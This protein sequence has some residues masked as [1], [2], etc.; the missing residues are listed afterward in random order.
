MKST[1]TLR[2]IIA[3]IEPVAG[4]CA[5]FEAELML[6]KLCGV[7]RHDLYT[8]ADITVDK[9]Q[10]AVLRSWIENRRSHVP[11]AHI[12]HQWHFYSCILT[13]TPHVLIPRSET[14]C[15]I[16][17]IL[18]CYSRSTHLYFCDIGTGSGNITAA[19]LHER[20]GWRAVSTDI[21]SRALRC[22]QRNTQKY[23]TRY[24]CCDTLEG[25]RPMNQ[26]DFIVSNPP[27]IPR[28]Q[29]SNLDSSVIDYEPVL[30]LDGGNDGL[31]FYRY[32]A[33]SGHRYLRPG[34]ALY[35]EIGSNQATQ[36]HRIFSRPP[37]SGI[38]IFSDMNS[39]PRIAYIKKRL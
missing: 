7:T 3:E 34:A 9:R 6:E 37:W 32:F 18:S 26:F 2:D 29:L 17:K 12:L 28:S 30:A 15:L 22:A 39:R 16:E 33:A 24:L 14:E 13:I 31:S 20:P 5:R 8:L 19:L 23:P 36:I 11:L 25:I 10:N 4:S 27:Y 35:C 38:N 1:E 21:C